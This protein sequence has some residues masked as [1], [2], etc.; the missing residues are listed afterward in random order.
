MTLDELG[1]AVRRPAP[2]LSLLENGKKQPRLNLVVE[3]AA[4]LDVDLAELLDPNPP[5]RRDALEIA[6]LRSQETP[7]FDSLHLPTVKPSA[8]LD[9]ETLT[10]LVGLHDALRERS[11][12]SSAGSED[13][14][15][16]NGEVTAW[17]AGHDGYLEQV[18]TE[19]RSALASSGYSGEGPFS[20]RNLLDLSASAG[21][22]LH[23]VEDMPSFAAVDHRPRSPPGLY[24]PA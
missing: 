15:R 6:L 2:Y 1:A 8:K 17:L 22:E 5:N 7:L 12:L 4:A 21:F 11:N 18:E 14:R 16:A 19:A 9:N 10:H 24:R 13:V 23:P 20:S 3:I